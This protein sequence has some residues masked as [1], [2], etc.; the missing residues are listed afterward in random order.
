MTISVN[1]DDY[2]I[3]FTLAEIVAFGRST[4]HLRAKVFRRCPYSEL[5]NGNGFKI[6]IILHHPIRDGVLP[7]LPC[8]ND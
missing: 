4:S 5:P 6:L 2:I 7:L 1:E 3:V 8:E